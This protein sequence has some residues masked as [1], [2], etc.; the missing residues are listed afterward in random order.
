MLL[1]SVFVVV[2]VVSLDSDLAAY[3]RVRSMFEYQPAEGD[4]L[5]SKLT[6]FTTLYRTY[7]ADLAQVRAVL[8]KSDWIDATTKAGKVSS[9][10]EVAAFNSAVTLEG[11]QAHTVSKR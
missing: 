2:S 6:T 3:E 11:L 7:V 1:L 4:A 9:G 8:S 5:V 10:G